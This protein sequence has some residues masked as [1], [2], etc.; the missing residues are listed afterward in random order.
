MNKD[1][2]R[3]YLV[4][5]DEELLC[6]GVVFSEYIA[7]LIRNADISFENGAYWSAIITS[8]AAIEGYFKSELNTNSKRLVDLINESNF[9]FN[10]IELLHNLRRYRNQIV[11]IK[12]PC[13]DE[14]ILN[15]YEEFSLNEE[16]VA[17][18]AIRL[19]RYVVYSEPFI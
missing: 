5:L 9:S 4:S 13:D 17:K 19:L 18:E 11:H 6:G 16:C 8:V 3:K 7:E 10:D 2:R 14:I 15:S 12:D 1:E